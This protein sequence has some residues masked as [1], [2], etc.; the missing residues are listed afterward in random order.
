MPYDKC[1]KIQVL[2]AST[3]ISGESRTS[4]LECVKSHNSI[5]SQKLL[6]IT[7][8]CVFLYECFLSFLFC[9]LF[10]LQCVSLIILKAIITLTPSEILE[11]SIGGVESLPPACGL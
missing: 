7:V 9:L 3:T 11:E 2:K 5:R 8:G 4:S 1:I 6:K 10:L